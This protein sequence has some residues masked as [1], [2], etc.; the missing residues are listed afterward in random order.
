ME[1]DFYNDLQILCIVYVSRTPESLSKC[2]YPMS[3]RVC[4]LRRV[5]RESVK[6]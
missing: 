3:E 4:F 2:K 1:G 5:K 6:H